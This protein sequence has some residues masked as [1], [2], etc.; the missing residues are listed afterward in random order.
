MA[1]GQTGE[2]EKGPQAKLGQ[3]GEV[4][5]LRPKSTGRPIDLSII[6]KL[7]AS[8]QPNRCENK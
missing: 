6:P 3:G 7:V 8:S 4:E 2:E 1:I 5:W